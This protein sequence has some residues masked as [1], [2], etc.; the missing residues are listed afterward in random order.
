MTL[1]SLCTSVPIVT[2]D[3]KTY[4]R[5]FGGFSETIPRK[6]QAQSLRGEGSIEHS[7]YHPYHLLRQLLSQIN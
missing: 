2:W 4:V 5:L 6:W 7:H 3:G 1:G